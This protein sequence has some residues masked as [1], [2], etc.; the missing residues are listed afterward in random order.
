MHIY[1]RT[2]GDCQDVHPSCNTN[3]DLGCDMASPNINYS[4]LPLRGRLEHRPFDF[5]LQRMPASRFVRTS[6]AM[7]KLTL[8]W[9]DHKPHVY[10]D[11][12][13]WGERR[14][15]RSPC[16]EKLFLFGESENPNSI[17]ET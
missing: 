3:L 4:Y 1:F 15:T 10:I 9:Q 5:E 17:A 2:S 14:T 11:R 7:A 8:A 12:L 6:S 16:E 13:Y